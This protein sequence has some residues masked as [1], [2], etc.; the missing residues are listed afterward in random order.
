MFLKTLFIL[1][2]ISNKLLSQNC[3][4]QDFKLKGPVKKIRY[5]EYF[6][7]LKYKNDTLAFRKIP[8]LPISFTLRFD[9]NGNMKLNRFSKMKLNFLKSVTFVLPNE[10]NYTKFN[11]KNDSVLLVKN[12]N[13][14][15]N[16]EFISYRYDSLSNT[17]YENRIL[18]NMLDSMFVYGN[19][20][21][22]YALNENSDMT[23]SFFISNYIFA[24][25]EEKVSEFEYDK[26]SNWIKKFEFRVKKQTSNPKAAPIPK[27]DLEPSCQIK[28]KI[29]YYK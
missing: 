10:E 11:L 12:N 26:H 14:P 2:L 28:R 23:Y 21:N 27:S 17:Y 22:Y 18:G 6:I 4:L 3:N 16:Y 5:T 13:T 8:L 20:I 1:L 29:N 7:N 15:F 9:R 25:H 24:L 19:I